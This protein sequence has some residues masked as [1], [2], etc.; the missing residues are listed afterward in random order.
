MR[1]VAV[2]DGEHY[3]DVV[4]DAFAE[5]P[6]DIVAAVVVGGTEKLRGAARSSPTSSVVLGLW[7]THQPARRR[8]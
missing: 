4:R 6:Y 2:I 5:L 1:A 7:T 8:W 3:A